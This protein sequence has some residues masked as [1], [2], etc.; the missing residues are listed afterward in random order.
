MRIGIASPPG[1]ARG[2]GRRCAVCVDSE[3]NRR[4]GAALSEGLVFESILVMAS[5]WVGRTVCRSAV[6]LA[7]LMGIGAAYGASPAPVSLGTAYRY[8]ILSKSG[9]QGVPASRIIGRV[10]TSP[11][12]GAA[13]H[14]TCPEVTGWIYSVDAAG[15]AP[16]GKIHPHLLTQAILDMQAAYRDAASRAPDVT[17]L[18]AG[19]IGGMTLKP[20]VYK[21]GTSVLIPTDVTLQGRSTDLWIFEIAQNLKIANGKTVLL[22]GGARAGNIVWQVGGSV[23]IGTT[24]NFKGTILSKTLIAMK[25]GASINGR[26]LA[27]TAVTLEMNS[28][29]RPN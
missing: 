9:I 7:G 24:A 16:C 18:G 28:V 8:A 27:Q 5:F 20:G 22:R 29:V 14:L 26:L 23:A 4:R 3:A 6:V 12:T 11:I 15:P 1:V 13:N 17:E 19:N 10:G 21:W 25:T 2:M